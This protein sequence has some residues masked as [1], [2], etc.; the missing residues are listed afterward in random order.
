M[1][2]DGSTVQ[3]VK[4][5]VFTQDT[6]HLS[7][8]GTLVENET[9]VG[10]STEYQKVFKDAKIT[11]GYDFNTVQDTE[12]VI[13]SEVMI[14]YHYVLDVANEITVTR[15]QTVPVEIVKPYRVTIEDEYVG[16]V[17]K[18]EDKVE[19]TVPCVIPI[20][21]SEI[22]DFGE[23]LTE[24]EWVKEIY[25]DE[26]C[27]SPTDV[28]EAEIKETSIVFKVAQQPDTDT[29]TVTKAS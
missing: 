25:S 18:D 10:G 23:S 22:G 2:V 11:S 12:P 3:K 13:Y 5:T 1:N 20:K 27:S 21:T 4:W 6:D 26:D 14:E 28:L 15:T 7:L 17:V 16:Y 24:Y 8:S 29:T 9:L 19:T